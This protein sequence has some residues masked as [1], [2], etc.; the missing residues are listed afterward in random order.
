MESPR[1]RFDVFPPGARTSRREFLAATSS[2]LALTACGRAPYDRRLF[3]IP[4][5]SPVG[6]YAAPTYASNFE[7]IVRRGL[8]ELDVDVR[9]RRVFLKPNMVEYERDTAINTNAMVVVGAALAF[10]A[11]GAASVTVGEGPG[12]RR[13]MEYLVTQTGLYEHLRESRIKFVDLNHDD[14]SSVPLR[15]HFTE[16]GQL[17]LPDELMRADF[18]VSMPKL[19]THHWAGMTASMKNLFGAVPGAVYGWPKNVLH[20][21]G[22]ENSILDLNSTIKPAFSIVDAVTAMEDDGPIMGRARHVG[23]LVMG[24][25]VVA[26]DGTCARMMGLDPE[27]LSYL[28]EAGNFLG[29]LDKSRITQRG[30][31]LARFATRFEVIDAFKRMQL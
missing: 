7:D 9:G 10:R 5:N 20:M 3:T 13:D 8:R 1:S 4:A 25:D 28:R 27:Q 30:E 19:K 6:I 31:P 17:A 29:N 2:A 15:S 14:V 11:A 21:E 24:R 23:C 18:I 26:V 22:I 16:L 12:H